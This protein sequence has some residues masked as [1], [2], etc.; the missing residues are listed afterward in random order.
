MPII[1]GYSVW[2]NRPLW[3]LRTIGIYAI[4]TGAFFFSLAGTKVKLSSSQNAF[5]I[6]A[7]VMA[8]T[9]ILCGIE[10]LS[11]DKFRSRYVLSLV[12]AI[13]LLIALI[14]VAGGLGWGILVTDHGIG[15][16]FLIAPPCVIIFIISRSI[17]K[18]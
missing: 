4:L 7:I 6:A 17:A 13:T 18:I 2:K 1:I 5:S 11:T 3:G 10:A 15:A 9:Y 16:P 8:A 14:L 12:S